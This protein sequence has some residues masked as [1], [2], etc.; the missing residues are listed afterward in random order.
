MADLN[1]KLEEI[2]RKLKYKINTQQLGKDSFNMKGKI[3]MRNSTIFSK[4]P[5]I[6]GVDA[7]T[8]SDSVNETFVKT[9]FN[10]GLYYNETYPSISGKSNTG[11]FGHHISLS[12]DGSVIAIG[13]TGQN[14]NAGIIEFYTPNNGD[15]VEMSNP[16]QG[17]AVEEKVGEMFELS[18]DGTKVVLG[19]RQDPTNGINA[20]KVSVYSYV[21]GDP[22][23]WIKIGDDILGTSEGMLFGTSVAIS[24][25]GNTI[26]IGASNDSTHVSN[27]GS[28]FVYRLQDNSW[29][30][31][32]STIY[33]ALEDEYVGHKVDISDDGNVI[34]ISGGSKSDAYDNS[35]YVSVYELISGEWIRIGESIED[36]IDNNGFGDNF[37]LSGDGKY[38]AVSSLSDLID[39]DSGDVR[40]YG[41]SNNI[42]S[43][44]GNR[45]D[46]VQAN[47]LLGASLKLSNGGKTFVASSKGSLNRGEIKQYSLIDDKWAQIGKTIV[48]EETEHVGTTLA[49][50]NDG[51]MIVFNSGIEH[52]LSGTD[53]IY[54]RSLN[55]FNKLQLEKP[56]NPI[57]GSTYFDTATNRLFC[58]NGLS[59]SMYQFI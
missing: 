55:N 6:K 17:I 7:R 46:G 59:W 50:T 45:I 34:A 24:N 13:N 43:I 48:G 28:I 39:I 18:G 37:S 31:L 1:S 41:V 21:P 56:E 25:D 3:T 58:Y 42:W 19:F 2:S 36:K 20:G 54:S 15:W 26:I 23:T 40:V 22:S 44:I 14:S 27:A 53:Y 38:I 12:N 47:D 52:A 11:S 9:L 29:K 10:S 16:I 4:A 35:G 5:Q 49:M 30:Q 33:G 57:V 51:K 32:G 8:S